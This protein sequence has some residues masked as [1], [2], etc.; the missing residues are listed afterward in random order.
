LG[1]IFPQPLKIIEPFFVR[2]VFNRDFV[3]K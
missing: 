2:Y 3:I 1:K